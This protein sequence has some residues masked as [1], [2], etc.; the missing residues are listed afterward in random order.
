M[1][2]FFKSSERRIILINFEGLAIYGLDNSRLMKLATFSEDEFGH[3]EFQHYL[4]ENKPSAVTVVVDSPAE[5]FI[6]EK[7]A[8]VNS[9]DRKSFLERKMDQHFRNI[10]Y[11]SAKVLGREE[12]GRRD[13]RVLFSALTQSQNIDGWVSLLLEQEISIKSITS[14]AFAICKVA[15]ELGLVTSDEILL[16]N[17]QRNG[18]R[19]SLIA[20]DKLIFSRLTPLPSGHDSDL[21]GVI[22]TAS[23]Q[24]KEYLDRIGLLKN[25]QQ[26]D[27]HVVTPVL[28]DHAFDDN[29]DTSQFGRVEHHNS[30]DL[31][32]IDQ[33]G[34]PQNE[35]T[36]ILLCLDWGVRT[37][38]FGNIYA[39]PAALRFKE[40]KQARNL[41][42][43]SCV[44]FMV[45]SGVLSAPALNDALERR[46]NYF[47]LSQSLLPVRDQYDALRAQFPETP[48]PSE[49]MELAVSNYE[50]IRGQMQQPTDLLAAISRA[51]QGYSAITLTSVTWELVS[52]QVDSSLTDALL[53]DSTSVNIELNG[54]QVGSSSFENSDTEL[55]S[56]INSLNLIEGATV[57]P[58][59]LPIESGANASLNTI[60]GDEILDLEFSLNVRFDS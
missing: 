32:P 21:V 28:E 50:L 16:V 30:I 22:M 41:I 17:W 39:S 26:L 47:G 8:H 54:S 44:L 23:L 13:D 3:E 37:G 29:A 4:A 36:A 59:K 35:I 40:L 38:K 9:F 25:A 55:K 60:V 10:E 58:I 20:N 2:G 46:N 42:V 5:D 51:I 12:S 53:T 18:I 43:L 27:L 7:V 57:T 49:A 56:F 1:F 19:Q 6:V 24:S 48:I 33:Y 14:P 45:L 52:D 34:G 11:C 15:K 31:M